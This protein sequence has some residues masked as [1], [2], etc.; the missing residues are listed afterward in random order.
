MYTNHEHKLVF[1]HNP[2][3][4]GKSIVTAL[5]G[6]FNDTQQEYIRHDYIS[7]LGGYEYLTVLRNPWGQVRSMYN[8]YKTASIR[9]VVS[10]FGYKK[11]K[12][13]LRY[14][15]LSLSGDLNSFVTFYNRHIPSQ[16]DFFS[17][18]SYQLIFENLESGWERFCKNKGYRYEPLTITHQKPET[19]QEKF[20]AD[21][22]NLIYER[23]RFSINLLN[24]TP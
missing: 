2:R 1:F 14:D 20:S 4:A 18:S 8:F 17:H 11:D 12:E 15:F 22:L 7:E 19:N 5:K 16:D 6:I 3:T 24:Y 23:N 21:S 13:A 9:S 10:S